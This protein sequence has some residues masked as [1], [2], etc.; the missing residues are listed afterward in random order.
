MKEFWRSAG[1]AIVALFLSLVSAAVLVAVPQ[2][3]GVPA[4]LVITVM[5]LL[6]LVLCMF[7]FDLLRA[8]ASMASVL[9]SLIPRKR[10][11]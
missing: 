8:C 1:E 4:M 7:V 6:G 10:R 2:L 11:D 5:V 9:I 3:D